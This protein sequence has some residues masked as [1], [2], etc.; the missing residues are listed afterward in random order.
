MTL[1][2]P[3]AHAILVGRYVVGRCYD[4]VAPRCSARVQTNRMVTV[5]E[6]AVV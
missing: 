3:L 5:S 6:K 4:V 2:I 1:F